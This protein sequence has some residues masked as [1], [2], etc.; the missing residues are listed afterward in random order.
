MRAHSDDWWTSVPVLFSRLSLAEPLLCR[1]YFTGPW[2]AAGAVFAAVWLA[3]A[4]L[5]ALWL[6]AAAPFRPVERTQN[7]SKPI[8]ELLHRGCWCTNYVPLF[9]C[10]SGLP[11][12]LC[13]LIYAVTLFSA[14]TLC[15]SCSL[16]NRIT[17][18]IQSLICTGHAAETS[19]CSF[20]TPVLYKRKLLTSS[21]YRWRE[22]PLTPL[23]VSLL[24]IYSYTFQ[25]CDSFAHTN[26]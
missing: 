22:A 23:K 6:V 13:L 2:P 20:S 1:G 9:S 16:C 24:F 18:I 21:Y 14:P 8:A 12:S 5:E 10:S 11:F 25:P 19:V 15:S 17:C 4:I 3:A 26:L 7:E